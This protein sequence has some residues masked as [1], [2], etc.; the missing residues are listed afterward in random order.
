MN[1]YAIPFAVSLLMGFF[2]RR[3]RYIYWLFIFLVA[4]FVGLRGNVDPDYLNYNYIFNISPSIGEGWGTLVAHIEEVKLEP[5]FLLVVSFLKESGA[6]FVFL[7]L[8]CSWVCFFFLKKICAFNENYWISFSYIYANAFVGLWVQI[9]F[10]VAIFLTAY[11]ILL[12][13][14]KHKIKSI[15]IFVVSM[16]V[17]SASIIYLPIIFSYRIIETFKI[18]IWKFFIFIFVFSIPLSLLPLR[19]Q[20]GDFLIFF[21]QRYFEYALEGGGTY[22]SF[23]YRVALISVLFFLIKKDK[24]LEEFEKIMMVMV[25]FSLLIWAIAWQFP[26]LYRIGTLCDTGFLLFLNRKIY[27]R[28]AKYL[29][30]SSIIFFVGVIRL[31]SAMQPMRDYIPFFE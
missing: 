27:S 16:L 9:R 23:L 6:N 21:N 17:Q 20:I 29:F 28:R 12:F 26:I 18:N 22:I 7:N 31:A 10:G 19:A 2:N 25:M 11:A 5:V 30:A 3:N 4:L 14:E 8:I 15:F 24:V 1:F 13:S